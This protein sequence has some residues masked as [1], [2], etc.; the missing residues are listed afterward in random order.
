MESFRKVLDQ[1]NTKCIGEGKDPSCGQLRKS[2]NEKSDPI[3]NKY[4]F[5]PNAKYVGLINYWKKVMPELYKYTVIDGQ[6]SAE[7]SLGFKY[8]HKEDLAMYSMANDCINTIKSVF[9]IEGILW[10]L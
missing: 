6:V 5:G 3:L 2:V 10:P 4:Y 1:Y 9:T 7:K 8:P